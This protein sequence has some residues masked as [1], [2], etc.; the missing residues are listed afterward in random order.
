MAFSIMIWEQPATLTLNNDAIEVKEG[1]GD[2]IGISWREKSA[3]NPPALSV[4]PGT[5][6]PLA[7]QKITVLPFVGL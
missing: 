5:D 4:A 3:T 2:R 6:E 7:A 1:S